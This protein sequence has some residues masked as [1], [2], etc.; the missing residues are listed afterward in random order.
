MLSVWDENKIV[1]P[2][3]FACV[4]A[5]ACV[6]FASRPSC[7]QPLKMKASNDTMKSQEEY[8]NCVFSA[9]FTDCQRE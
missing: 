5:C 8:Y 1:K 2:I 3:K 6:Y 4:C 7:N 9:S